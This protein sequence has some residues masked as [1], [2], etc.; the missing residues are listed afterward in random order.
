[1]FS[2][3][4]ICPT[5]GGGGV[6]HEMHEGI[7][8]MLGGGGWSCP[9]GGGGGGDIH[10]QDRSLTSP[11]PP[12]QDRS[13]TPPHPPNIRELRS[14]R[15]RYASYWNAYL[16]KNI[17]NKNIK[18]ATVSCLHVVHFVHD[19]LNKLDNSWH[20]SIVENSWTASYRM[21]NGLLTTKIQYLRKFNRKAET[22][23]E[24]I[25]LTWHEREGNF[26]RLWKRASLA[27]GCDIF[28]NFS[29][30]YVEESYIECPRH[31]VSRISPRK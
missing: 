6:L 10:H 1:M 23:K 3:A 21:H 26:P 7:G 9:G 13:L 18:T 17:S 30:I 25:F 29:I 22:W 2:Q 20:N 5:Q 15:G 27:I 28:R 24:I 11:P 8:H 31:K 4:S 14:M 16:F 12:H 19:A